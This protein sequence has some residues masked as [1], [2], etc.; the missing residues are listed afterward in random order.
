ML[1]ATQVWLQKS[2]QS[3]ALQGPSR[4]SSST[5]R[6]LNY[7]QPCWEAFFDR[8]ELDLSAILVQAIYSSRIFD[9]YRTL[10]VVIFLGLFPRIN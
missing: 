8:S 7:S 6:S 9:F 10:R 2:G 4:G 5:Y 3:S 1:H